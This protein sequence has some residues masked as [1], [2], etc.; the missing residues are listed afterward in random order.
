MVAPGVAIDRRSV[1]SV[2]ARRFDTITIEIMGDLAWRAPFHILL[3]N[4]LN[5]RSFAFDND[6]LAL[7]A[8]H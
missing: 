4:P 3:E 5:D 6:A 1:P 2:A 8:G 7:A